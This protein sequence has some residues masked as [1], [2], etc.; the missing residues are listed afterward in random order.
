MFGFG[1]S[2]E[3]KQKRRRERD[4]LEHKK[5]ASKKAAEE[6]YLE[7]YKER[8]VENAKVIAQRDADKLANQQPFYQKLVSGGAWLLK[9][10]SDGAGKVNTDALFSW[11]TKPKRKRRKH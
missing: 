5:Q 10:L 2:S 11:E 3:E 6:A 9:D 7:A 4:I 8:R 1:V